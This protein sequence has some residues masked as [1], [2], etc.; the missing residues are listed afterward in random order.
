VRTFIAVEIDEGIRERLVAA[1]ARLR[2][3][4]PGFRWSRVEGMHLTLKF[5]GEIGEDTVEPVA[6][7]MAEAAD[8][9]VP[10]DVRVAGVGS[11]PPRGA[12]RVLW[13]GVEDP[14]GLLAKLQGG[15][16]KRLASLGFEPERRAFHPHVTL[17]RAK[18]RRGGRRS[19]TP[20]GEREDEFG[21]QAVEEAVLFQSTLG[22][23][24]AVYTPLRHHRLGAAGPPASPE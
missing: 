2:S 10:F 3:A 4:A 17:A 14:T 9:I 22:P 11:F 12:P 16:D 1:Q 20:L 13:A 15:L 21:V 8:G 24:G 5:L 7:A 23:G 18:D 19:A 6:A